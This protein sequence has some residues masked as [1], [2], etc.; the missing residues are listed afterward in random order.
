MGRALTCTYDK[1]N[2]FLFLRTEYAVNSGGPLKNLGFDTELWVHATE[3][4]AY[5][6]ERALAVRSLSVGAESVSMNVPEV[7]SRVEVSGRLD[8]FVENLARIRSASLEA[9]VGERFDFIGGEARII[10]ATTEGGFPSV[11]FKVSPLAQIPDE[12]IIR[13]PAK[14]S[15]RI[16]NTSLDQ[17]S[18]TSSTVPDGQSL[19]GILH[20]G[21]PVPSTGSVELRL[22][23]WTVSSSQ[24]VTLSAFQQGCLID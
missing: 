18:W 13:G 22:D 6:Q 16:G 1:E 3:A 21:G 7:P 9:L 19:T 12:I 14:A 8:W 4:N 17:P 10:E 2:D 5:V 24:P 15:L 11:T 20:F 23:T